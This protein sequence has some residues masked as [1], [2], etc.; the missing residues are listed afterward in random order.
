MKGRRQIDRQDRIPFCD[1]KLVEWGDELNPGIIDE[2]VELAVLRDGRSDHLGDRL[3]LG[4]IGRR[5]AHLDAKIGRNPLPGLGDFRG[6]A[7]AVQHHGRAGLGQR[8]GDSKADAA[9]GAGDQRD[10][11]H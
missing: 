1:R 5:I 6:D 4:H 11:S 8:A 7:E 10:S 9:G 2:H 3:R